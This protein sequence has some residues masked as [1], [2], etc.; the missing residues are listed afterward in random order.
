[1]R[2][3]TQYQ[4]NFFLNYFFKN[5]KIPTWEL[6]ATTLLESGQ[7][8]VAGHE[9]IWKGGVGNFIKTEDTRD[10]VGCLLY[11][12]DLE[13]FITSEWYKQIK[14]EYI[15]DLEKNAIAIKRECQ[16]LSEL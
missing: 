16:E 12:F 7:C 14:D 6:V 15:L 10:A 8:I 13:N 11:K 4:K 3:L 2:K 9:P 1:M 5:E